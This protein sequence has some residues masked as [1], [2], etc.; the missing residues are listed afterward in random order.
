[1]KTFLRT[2]LPHALLLPLALLTVTCAAGP[3][4]ASPEIG[5]EAPAFTLPAADGETHSLADFRGQVVVLEWVN[6]DCPFVKKHYGSGNMQALQE[7]YTGEGVVWLSVNSSA[8][9][10]QGHVTPEQALELTAEKNAAPTAV[11]LDPEGD[12][13]QSYGARTTPHMYVIDEDGVLVYMGA[14]DDRPTTDLDDVEGATNYVTAALDAVLAGGTPETQVTKPY[15]C[16]V[17]Y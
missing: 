12:V 1:M 4:L 15:G 9:G 13:G 6:H 14:I 2:L 5:Q 17:K 3:A 10:K 16:S 11:L 8:P 7:K